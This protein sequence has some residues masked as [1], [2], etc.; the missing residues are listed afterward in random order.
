MIRTIIAA[1]VAVGLGACDNSPKCLVDAKDTAVVID[2]DQLCSSGRYDCT[3]YDRLR[4]TRDA[5][6]TVCAM[7]S[8]GWKYKV[9]DKIRG[10]M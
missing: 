6:G 9:G 2:V 1:I 10:P 7:H 5:D 3:R 8:Y 4:M